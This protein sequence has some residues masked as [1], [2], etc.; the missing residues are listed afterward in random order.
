MKK[1]L[2]LAVALLF[3]PSMVLAQAVTATTT[4]TTALGDP[5]VIIGL[6]AKAFQSGDWM[7]AVGLLLTLVVAGFKL[8]GINK[9]V[10]KQH[11]KWL[12][13]GLSLVTS[14]AV[15]LMAHATWW[16]IISTG[17]GAGVIAVGG[18]EVLLEPVVKFIKKKI[19]S[20]K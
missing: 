4:S 19:G 18:W 5:G 3:V 7:L 8:L 13:G 16:A 1:I 14:V 2:M 17:L 11:T 20:D 12:A 6:M 10:P 15:G 9:L